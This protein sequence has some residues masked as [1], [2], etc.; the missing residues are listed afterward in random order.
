VPRDNQ[1]HASTHVLE[2]GHHAEQVPDVFGL[3]TTEKDDPRRL[4]GERPD[5]R[6]GID[7]TAVREDVSLRTGQGGT[8]VATDHSPA[9]ANLFA[10]H[11]GHED[12]QVVAQ[13]LAVVVKPSEP[14]RPG[15]GQRDQAGIGLDGEARRQVSSGQVQLGHEHRTGLRPPGREA[16]QQG[17]HAGR[18]LR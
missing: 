9:R 15:G 4:R 8:E 11:R 7:A 10:P 17:R 18:A 5:G 14:A 2:F 13:R 16:Q 6:T 3:R 12:A 1:S